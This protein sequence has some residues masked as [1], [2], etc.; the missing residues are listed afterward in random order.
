ML[1]TRRRK[2]QHH[3]FRRAQLIA[4]L[5]HPIA[6]SALTWRIGNRLEE[7]AAPTRHQRS[8]A[9]RS[10][11]ASRSLLAHLRRD[12]P[13]AAKIRQLPDETGAQR[14]LRRWPGAGGG[15][16]VLVRRLVGLRAGHAAVGQCGGAAD[17]P[18]R[19]GACPGRPTP[20]LAGVE[21][22][23]QAGLASRLAAPVCH[24]PGHAGPG[25]GH[26]SHR[27]HGR[28]AHRRGPSARRSAAWSASFGA[29][30]PAWC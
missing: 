19:A 12:A 26:L 25:V 18:A 13:T 1:A 28:A 10:A 20:S 2:R 16:G 23:R 6:S 5:D 7:P 14:G 4:S 22:R 24:A 30:P 9:P 11:H 3:R 29:H 21:G 8:Q 17:G 15:L 27:Q